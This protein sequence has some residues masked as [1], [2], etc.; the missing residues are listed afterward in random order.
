[1]CPIAGFAEMPEKPSDPPHF[2]PTHKFD[3]G[4]GV[5]LALFASTSPKKVC[6]MVSSIIADSEPLF[7]CSKMNKGF[8]KFGDRFRISFLRI[9]ICAC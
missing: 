2:S 8:S 9:S 6:R 1:M 4:A 5:R 7:C 3:S